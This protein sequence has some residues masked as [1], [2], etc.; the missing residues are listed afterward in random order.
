MTVKPGPVDTP[1][2]E[3]LDRLPF[4]VSADRA[5]S[6]ILRAAARGAATVYVPARWRVIMAIL[7]V[8]P[9]RIFRRLDL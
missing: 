8:I 1:M 4:L 2:S 9:S 3:G 6:I 7:R 5:A